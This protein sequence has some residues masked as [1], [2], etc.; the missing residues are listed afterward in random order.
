MR[1]CISFKKWKTDEQKLD[2]VEEKEKTADKLLGMGSSVD[3]TSSAV[4]VTATVKEKEGA[5][6][7][8]GMGSSVDTTSPAATVKEKEEEDKLMGM[9]SSVDTTSSSVTVNISE[10]AKSLI[11]NLKT[12]WKEEKTGIEEVLDRIKS[13]ADPNLK[14]HLLG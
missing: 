13:W 10:I 12:R 1:K 3:T 5:D 4:T 6:K 11:G 8:L 2:G 9:G 14:V 7:L